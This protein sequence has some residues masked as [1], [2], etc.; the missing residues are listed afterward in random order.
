MKRLSNSVAFGNYINKKNFASVNRS[1]G[2][3]MVNQEEA[4]SYLVYNENTGLYSDAI[5]ELCSG[6]EAALSSPMLKKQNGSYPPKG[7]SVD[8]IISLGTP[9]NL[10]SLVE[11]E[12][13]LDFLNKQVE[14]I[15]PESAPESDS[16]SY[17]E[18]DSEPAPEPSSE[19]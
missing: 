15:N 16:E 1:V 9:Q 11:R 2:E 8:E 13:Y 3:G 18:S 10:D 6:N 7:L 19:S 5:S 17:S 12:K 14:I 4:L